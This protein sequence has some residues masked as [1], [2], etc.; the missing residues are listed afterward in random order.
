MTEK[1]KMYKTAYFTITKSFVKILDAKKTE[2][3]WLYDIDNDGE[4]LYHI[5][6]YYL[7]QFCL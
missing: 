2:I 5:H 7:E 4:V 3:G 6:E 1:Q